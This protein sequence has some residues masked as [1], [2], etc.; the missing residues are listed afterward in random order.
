M[1]C[2]AVCIILHSKLTLYDRSI[3]SSPTKIIT[4]SRPALTAYSHLYG[5]HFMSHAAT[6]HAKK[7]VL[8]HLNW[9]CLHVTHEIVFLRQPFFS[10]IF[11][12]FF[13]WFTP[14][15]KL[16]IKFSSKQVLTIYGYTQKYS[17]NFSFCILLNF[18]YGYFEMMT[19]FSSMVELL[20]FVNSPNAFTQLHR[21][22]Q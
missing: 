13:P 20:K 22:E 8:M 7:N 15:E 3:K 2:S 12:S 11:C 5:I 21:W 6:V 18:R 19:Q 4:L 14:L 10:P 9:Y 16:V 1:E 17:F